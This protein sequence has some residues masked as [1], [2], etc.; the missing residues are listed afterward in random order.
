MIN[1]LLYQGLR[2]M[3]ISLLLPLFIHFSFFSIF[4]IVDSM[5]VRTFKFYKD[6]DIELLYCG[7]EN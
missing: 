7:N 5:Q 3:L 1:I 2:L 6:M 4:H